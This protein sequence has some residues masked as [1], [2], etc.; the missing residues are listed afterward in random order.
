M[1]VHVTDDRHYGE[2][3]IW[4]SY[5]ANSSVRN[6]RTDRYLNQRDSMDQ[7]YDRRFEVDNS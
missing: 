6:R 7:W 1:D 5:D 4:Q 3:T 2:E